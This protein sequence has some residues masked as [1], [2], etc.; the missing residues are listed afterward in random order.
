MWVIIKSSLYLLLKVVV[1]KI[2]SVLWVF[3]IVND[4]FVKFISVLYALDQQW[5]HC[6]MLQTYSYIAIMLQ[7]EPID[8]QLHLY[9][10]LLPHKLHMQIDI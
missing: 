3:L 8:I 4:F 7:N 2:I 10:C 6:I 5:V 1:S 9:I